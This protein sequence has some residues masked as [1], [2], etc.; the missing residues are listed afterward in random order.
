MFTVAII[1]DRPLVRLGLEKLIS[2]TNDLEVVASTGAVSE[3]DLR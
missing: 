3:L 1:D 2:E